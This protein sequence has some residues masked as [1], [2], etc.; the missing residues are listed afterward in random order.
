MKKAVALVVLCAMALSL[1]GCAKKD[2]DSGKSGR[3]GDKQKT[4]DVQDDAY[5]EESVVGFSSKGGTIVFN[6]DG[7]FDL[8]EDAW[9]GFCTG[10]KGFKDEVDADEYDVAY[11][12]FDAE[13]STA[14]KYVFEFEKDYVGSLED[15]NY[16]VVLCD[17]DDEGKVILYFPAVKN[18]DDIKCDFDKITINK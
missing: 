11:T 10:T 3:D 1:F 16:I 18:G 7:G 8:Y 17:S 12:Y 13:K 15:G 6:V 4:E 9:L 2:A 14:S 5:S